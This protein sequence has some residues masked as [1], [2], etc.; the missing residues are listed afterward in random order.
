[1]WENEPWV[2]HWWPQAAQRAQRA[3]A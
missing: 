1:V 3:V 2:D